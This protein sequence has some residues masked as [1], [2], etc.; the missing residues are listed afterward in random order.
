MS[1]QKELSGKDEASK[2]RVARGQARRDLRD[3]QKKALEAAGNSEERSEVK[4][5]FKEQL[6]GLDASQNKEG[7]DDRIENDGV[8]K[9]D[10]IPP[11]DISDFTET[12]FIM[13]VNG[14]PVSGTIL[15]KED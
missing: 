11:S 10:R 14:A 15:F 2:K 1:T 7:T 12:A 5:S 4:K 13:C 6:L 3:K 8:D 9:I